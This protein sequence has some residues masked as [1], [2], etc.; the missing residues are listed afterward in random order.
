MMITQ[1]RRDMLN[2]LNIKTKNK[3]TKEYSGQ[4]SELI[5]MYIHY[6][7]YNKDYYV[8]NNLYCTTYCSIQP[9]FYHHV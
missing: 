8:T 5:Y 6:Y 1:K 7:S 4:D 3:R 2:L 9:F